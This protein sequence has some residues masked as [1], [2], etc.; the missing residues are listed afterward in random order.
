MVFSHAV[1]HDGVIYP[2][3]TEVPVEKGLLDEL[4]SDDNSV[5]KPPAQEAPAQEE[6]QPRKRGRKKSS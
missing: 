4:T 6:Q 1:K 2:A 5:I 3:G